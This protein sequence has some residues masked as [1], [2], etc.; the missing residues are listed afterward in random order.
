MSV[1]VSEHEETGDDSAKGNLGDHVIRTYII[2]IERYTNGGAPDLT[3]NETCYSSYD[4]GYTVYCTQ[5]KGKGKGEMTSR[6][7][8]VRCGKQAANQRAPLIF[9]NTIFRLIVPSFSF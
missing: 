8:L 5:S 1:S 4:I 6:E 7:R 3:K 2:I 9:P